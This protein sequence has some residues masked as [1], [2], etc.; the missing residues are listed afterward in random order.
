MSKKIIKILVFACWFG[1]LVPGRLYPA[2]GQGWI[3]NSLSISLDARFSL[4]LTQ[5]TRFH[6]P[7]YMDPYLKNWQC[8][9]SYKLPK[10][11]YL[12]AMY[13]RE[14]VQKPELRIAEDRV[15]FESGW[16][17]GLSEAVS[18]DCRFRTEIRSYDQE[19]EQNHL[20]FRMRIRLRME[21]N[22]GKMRLRPF[23]ATEP[24]GDSKADTINR[25][26]FYL[27][28]GIILNNNFELTINYIRQDT[29]GKE[30]LHILNSGVQLK[31]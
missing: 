8:G 27:G 15:T 12:A 17:T 24:F 11:F 26:R 1:A 22:I 13:K 19:V 16:K 18:F 14:H 6:E 25:N 31:F 3:N 9:L 2:D 20:R 29:R 5:E 28:T 21:M 7:T 23:I 4:L 30:T 10:N